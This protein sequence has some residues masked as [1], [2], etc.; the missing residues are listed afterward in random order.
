MLP[1]EKLIELEGTTWRYTAEAYNRDYLLSF[2]AQ[3]R[4]LS[5][6]PNERSPDNDFWEQRGNKLQFSY[7]DGY[8]VSTGY[9][10]R[11]DYIKGN[12]RNKKGEEWV[13]ELHLVPDQLAYPVESN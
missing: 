8:S 7:N 13:W 10:V 4:L 5:K 9:L 2:L 6:H 12:S 3:G 11:P 1:Q